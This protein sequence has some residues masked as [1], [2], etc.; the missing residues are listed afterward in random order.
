M[1]IRALN[2]SYFRFFTSWRWNQKTSNPFF[3]SQP[4]TQILNFKQNQAHFKFSFSSAQDLIKKRDFLGAI[5]V[6]DTELQKNPNDYAFWNSKGNALIQLGRMEESLKCFDESIR[7]CGNFKYSWYNK[8]VALFHLKKYEE[9]LHCFD[10]CLK[11]HPLFKFGLH[12]RAT[13][14]NKLQRYEE[15]VES[16]DQA[17]KVFPFRRISWLG[18]SI[19]L[20]KLGRTKE[21]RECHL[22]AVSISLQLKS[23]A[24]KLPNEETEEEVDLL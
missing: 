13:C 21:A 24:K 1:L 9:A 11:I 7:I 10:V 18:K 8:G 20:F 17:L 19:A 5:A 3:F 4:S 22:R 2:K 14:L 6:C 15:A 23:R 16:F 12:N